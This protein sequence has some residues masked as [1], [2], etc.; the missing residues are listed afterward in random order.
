MRRGCDYAPV[1][2]ATLPIVP[3]EPLRTLTWVLLGLFATSLPTVLAIVLRD[4]W[5]GNPGWQRWTQLRIVLFVA[6]A[7]GALARLLIP[8]R[9]AMHYMGYEL[10]AEAQALLATPKYGPAAFQLEHVVQQVLGP[11]AV[12]SVHAMIG[13]LF[14]P[15]AAGLLMRVGGS[16]VATVWCGALVALTPVL[17]RDAATESLLVPTTLWA[18]GGAC[19][20]ARFVGTRGSGWLVG[21]MIWCLL[22]MLARPEAML[23]VPTLAVMAAVLAGWT[24]PRAVRS[25]PFVALGIGLGVGCAVMWLRVDQLMVQMAIERARGNTPQVFDR[26]WF[27]VGGGILRDALW[28]KNGLLWPSL[29]PAAVPAAIAVGLLVSRGLA[30]RQLVV[31]LALTAVWIAPTAIDLPWVSVP[32]VQAPALLIAMMA[33]AVALAAITDRAISAG[34]P[35]FKVAVG[36]ALAAAVSAAVT[37][38]LVMRTDHTDIEHRAFL[39]A[40]TALPAD[41]VVLA[42]SHNDLPDERIHMALPAQTRPLSDLVSGR[43]RWSERPVYAWLGTRCFLRPC[44]QTAEHPA[45]A[46]MRVRYTLEPILTAQVQLSDAQLPDGFGR[47]NPAHASAVPDLDFPWCA[48][49]QRFAI[50]MFKVIGVAAG[51]TATR[52]TP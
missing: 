38:P 30:R 11:A 14:A 2:P 32:R 4:L 29:V 10:L 48:M 7:A 18:L 45:C 31:W 41:A 52:P 25:W 46:A 3:D 40:S 34:R 13:A 8:A 44:S 22:A 5:R 33:G 15:L 35:P 17:V 43:V 24:K 42:R 9:M 26:S 28:T 1:N 51:S 50:G 23:T 49:K 27:A 36:L 16:A 21:A 39:A 37:L 20:V 19:M 6:I 12:P 47:Q